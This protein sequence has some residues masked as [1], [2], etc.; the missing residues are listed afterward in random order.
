MTLSKTAAMRNCAPA[1]LTVS[2][3]SEPEN[4]APRSKFA[5]KKLTRRS[6]QQFLKL[7]VRAKIAPAKLNSFLKIRLSIV[8]LTWSWLKL[9][10]I[11]N[12]FLAF[13]S[14]SPDNGDARSN[15]S[16]STPQSCIKIRRC[17]AVRY[18]GSKVDNFS[19]AKYFINPFQR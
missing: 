1:K 7:I 19:S 13:S 16:L 5:S 17:S 18:K 14:S 3:N 4:T 12:N 8:I 2:K 6:K 10:S 11:G 9:V 15:C